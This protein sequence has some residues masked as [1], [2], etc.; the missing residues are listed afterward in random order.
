VTE[1][2][3]T[4]LFLYS[5]AGAPTCRATLRDSGAHYSNDTIAAVVRARKERLAAAVPDSG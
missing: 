2:R 1:E 5:D 4:E 3:T